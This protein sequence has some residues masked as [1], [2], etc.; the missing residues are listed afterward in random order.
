[1]ERGDELKMIEKMISIYGTDPRFL[2]LKAQTIVARVSK[3]IVYS[4]R[5][6]EESMGDLMIAHKCA[7]Q[8]LRAGFFPDVCKVIIEFT[9]KLLN[10]SA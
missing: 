5:V 3:E 4:R 6:S 1:M 8:A 7:N 9:S 2:L 10:R